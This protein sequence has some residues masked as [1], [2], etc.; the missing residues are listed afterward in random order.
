MSAPCG[1]QIT[2][3][4]TRQGQEKI[5]K[6]AAGPASRKIWTKIYNPDAA[7]PAGPKIWRDTYSLDAAGP[8]GP[9]IRKNA[10]T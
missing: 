6:D 5:E 9:K 2:Y 7:G 3:H 8:T 4:S 1:G 10:T